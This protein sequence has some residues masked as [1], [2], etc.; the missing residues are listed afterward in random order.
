M[1]E[2]RNMAEWKSYQGRPG[3]LPGLETDRKTK[4]ALQGFFRHA[5]KQI[6]RGQLPSE[7]LDFGKPVIVRVAESDHARGRHTREI[8]RELQGAFMIS[9]NGHGTFASILPVSEKPYNDFA[10]LE[11]SI[12]QC[13]YFPIVVGKV[14]G[15]GFATLAADSLFPRWVRASA[16]A[17]IAGQMN[18]LGMIH[19]NSNENRSVEH[20]PVRIMDGAMATHSG[21]YE[22]RFAAD[23]FRMEKSEAAKK[24]DRVVCDYY[25]AVKG[26]NI[27][28]RLMGFLEQKKAAALAHHKEIDPEMIIR[29]H[30]LEHWLT[31]EY[32]K[33][34]GALADLIPGNLKYTVERLI[35]QAH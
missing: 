32:R 4:Q 27:D 10:E 20:A 18:G 35:Y 28:F 17:G 2:T 9:E 24:N 29:S 23:S 30:S 25:F 1:A 16:Y 13:V 26:A 12:G 3:W 31:E 19:M 7:E 14:E 11:A 33:L 34:S 22:I 21:E 5:M 8:R 15:A 6:G